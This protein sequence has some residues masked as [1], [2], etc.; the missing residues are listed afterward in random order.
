MKV[1][2]APN[3]PERAESMPGRM[4]GGEGDGTIDVVATVHSLTHEV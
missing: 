4:P 2:R 1:N 3:R